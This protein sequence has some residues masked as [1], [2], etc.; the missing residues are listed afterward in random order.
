MSMED[1]RSCVEDRYPLGPFALE[2]SIHSAESRFHCEEEVLGAVVYSRFH[3][4]R[5]E[6]GLRPK[7]PG[8]GFQKD[9][10]ENQRGQLKLKRYIIAFSE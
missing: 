4:R 8:L 5:F 6:V 3:L 7:S 10:D 9:H 1:I 2:R